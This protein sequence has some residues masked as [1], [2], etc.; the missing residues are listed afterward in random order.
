MASMTNTCVA[1][2][3]LVTILLQSCATPVL[4]SPY[5]RRQSG[6]H[7]DL[8]RVFDYV[9]VGAGPG[10]SIMANRLTEQSNVTVALVEAGTWAENV[11]G[12]LTEVPAYDVNFAYKAAN[13]TKYGVDWGFVTTPQTGLQGQPVLG[14]PRGKALGGSTNL[15]AMAWGDSTRGTF[16]KWAN[17]VGDDSFQYDTVVNYY[18][19]A[20]NFTPPDDSTRL[21]NATP[22]YNPD[23]VSVGGPLDISYAAYSY[24]WTTWLQV[25]LEGLGI[26]STDSFIKGDLNGSAWQIHTINHTTGFR[27]S[28]DRAY[29]RPYLQRPNLAIF[30]RTMG[31]RILFNGNRKAVGVQVT[32]DNSSY[33]L[34]ATR[35]VIVAAG[36]FQS[37]QLLQVSGVGPAALLERYDIP[38]VADRPGVGQNMVDHLLFGVSHR[39]NVPTLSTLVLG[40]SGN[41]EVEEFNAHP[42][43]GRLTSPGGELVGF[44]NVPEALRSGFSQ[45]TV[46]ALADFPSDWPEIEYLTLP[47]FVGDFTGN[48]PAPNDG[49]N[50]ATL[51]GTLMT[52]TSR[53]NISISSSRMADP[54]L[55]N[56]NY[57]TTRADIEV[58]VAMFKRLRQAWAVPAIANNL[59]IGDEFYP[60]Q[61]IQTDEEIEALIRRT[62]AP[63]SH[64]VGTNKM[65]RESD[66][67]AVVDSHGK[68]FGVENYMLGEKIA[69]DVK[70][71]L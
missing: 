43:T 10:G 1:F 12:N 44:E 23:L 5:L 69:D 54:P 46:Q 41:R 16:D 62:M 4:A 6:S 70:R 32:S 71:G 68:V 58:S 50:Y 15:N 65:G 7:R 60:G 57:L 29:L 47:T 67:L 20:T 52:P 55:I 48:P 33:T 30:D 2:T 61:E 26:K 25:A 59:T 17:E 51:L 40:D 19:K 14:Y 45:E 49:Y 9:I 22:R 35:E 3:I 53:G 38:L 34:K 11:V 39:V 37:P 27:E 28:A 64:A 8:G 13:A 24:S 63:V 36:V 18:R 42:P 31:E 66:P 21:A 56:P